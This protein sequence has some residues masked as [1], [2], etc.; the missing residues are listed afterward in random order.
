MNRYAT[1]RSRPSPGRST[2]KT[3]YRDYLPTRYA[4]LDDPA[5]YFRMGEQIQDRVTDLTPQLAGLDRP[6]EG[7]SG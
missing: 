7:P 3:Y 5:K 1:T 6:G 4:E 2:A